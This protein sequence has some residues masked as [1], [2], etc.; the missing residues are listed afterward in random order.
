MQMN[1][2]FLFFSYKGD[3]ILLVWLPSMSCLRTIRT[4]FSVTCLRLDENDG[5]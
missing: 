4:C 5:I 1:E 2:I 3:L